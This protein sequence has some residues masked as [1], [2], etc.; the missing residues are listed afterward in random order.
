MFGTCDGEVHPTS[1][2]GPVRTLIE[3]RSD[4]P[5]VC[6]TAL[7]Q[8]CP[9]PAQPPPDKCPGTHCGVYELHS[10]NI[11]ST[12]CLLGY[13]ASTGHLLGGYW[14]STGRLSGI[15]WAVT[16]H[17]LGGYWANTFCK[18]AE[19]IIFITISDNVGS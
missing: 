10:G 17:L 4:M 3:R 8:G 13:R 6:L 16:G 14:A 11:V 18:V 15:Y 12:G 7:I 9:V 2:P 1:K 5:A 19:Y